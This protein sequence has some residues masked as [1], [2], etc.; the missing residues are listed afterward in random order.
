MW[1]WANH[2][3][4]LRSSLKIYKSRIITVSSLS[5]EKHDVK[6]KEAMHVKMLLFR[7]DIFLYF[8]IFSYTAWKQS[9]SILEII[10]KLIFTWLTQWTND[11]KQYENWI[12]IWP[13]WIKKG[14]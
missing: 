3:T 2:L 4:A 12:T 9:S 11:V 8:N 1:Y 10:L 14:L 5:I 13:K 7:K 6:I